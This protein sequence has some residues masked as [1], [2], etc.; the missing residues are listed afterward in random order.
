MYFH[1]TD[2]LKHVFQGIHSVVFF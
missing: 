2:K 1:I